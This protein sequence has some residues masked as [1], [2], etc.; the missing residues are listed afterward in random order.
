MQIHEVVRRYTYVC[1]DKGETLFIQAPAH[2]G[3]TQG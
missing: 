1:S 3:K 2:K